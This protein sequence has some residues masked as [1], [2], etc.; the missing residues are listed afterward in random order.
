VAFVAPN[1]ADTSSEDGATMSQVVFEPSVRVRKARLARKIRPFSGLLVITACS[2]LV[3]GGI[4]LGGGNVAGNGVLAMSV[5]CLMVY[6]WYKWDL[7]VLPVRDF[8]G[9]ELKLDQVLSGELAAVLGW[10]MSAREIWDFVSKTVEGQFIIGR[11]ELDSAVA[12]PAL[13]NFDGEIDVVWMEA[14]RLQQTAGLADVGAAAIVSALLISYPHILEA[15]GH[16]SVQ[17]KDVLDTFWWH[18][19]IRLAEEAKRH[20]LKLGGIGRDWASGY[21]PI[22]SRYAQ[23]IS[24]YVE[25]SKLSYF[26]L[27]RSKTLDQIMANLGRSER[28]NV[29]LVGPTG[30]GKTETVYALAERLLYISQQNST[31]A[32]QVMG[33]NPA[34][35]TSASQVPGEIEQLMMTLFS[36][37]LHAGN[38][39]VFLDEAQLFMQRGVGALDLSQLLLTITQQTHLRIIMALAPGDYQHMASTNPAL[40]G[41]F[42]VVTMPELTQ[43]EVIAVLQD[44]LVNLE[45]HSGLKATYSSLVE[46][47]R[48][49]ARHISTVSF[50][51][52]AIKLLED[53]FSY[54][55]GKFITAKSVQLC[56]EQTLGVKAAPA[57][58][59]EKEKL[60]NLEDLLHQKLINQTHA[61]S[62]VSSALRRNRAGVGSPKRPAGSFL[63]IGPTGVGKTELTKALAD[64]YFGG[65]DHI[66]R[67]D[68]SEYQQAADVTRLI[69]PSAQG[70]TSLLTEVRQRPFSVVLLDE[71][72]KGHPDILNLLLQML[73]EGRLTDSSGQIADFTNCIIIA[74]SNAGADEI[75]AHVAAGE[76]L[77]QFEKQI[78]EGLIASHQFKPELINRFDEVV[79]FRP[80]NKEELK[81]VVILMLAEVNATLANQNIS[82]ELSD[83]AVEYLV[84]NGYDPQFGARP[85]RR[86]IQQTVQ[87]R[88]ADGILRGQ[89]KAGSK[90]NLGVTDLEQKTL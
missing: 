15:V 41:Q 60:L 1:S 42:N 65:T 28:H 56:I 90:V 73:D 67:L 5:A 71:L 55:V 86:L 40:A 23:N 37:A 63:F 80:L 61:V 36:D 79:L 11:L 10:P 4:L 17:S 19:R 54:P 22:L 53:S 30:S 49:A 24:K 7:A 89:I 33:L 38:M 16:S 18:T 83:T 2:L 20:Q 70:G 26:S 13:D 6:W 76:E 66:I 48:L 39:M 87:N 75:R 84:N 64:V 52:K 74:T 3:G 50:P 85:L 45:A 25:E 68:M 44:R 31:T 88:V 81:Q 29:V 62:A 12:G 46:S 9:E 57:G 35:I 78:E 14:R 8:S 72:E 32:F 43:L 21:T 27:A 47:Y 77:S 59:Q 82:V 69:A 51:G 34:L 58:E